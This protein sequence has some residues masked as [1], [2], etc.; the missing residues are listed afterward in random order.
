M[1]VSLNLFAASTKL[2]QNYVNTTFVDDAHAFGGQAQTHEAVF[3]LDPEAVMLQVRQE[4]RRV[5]LFA[6]EMLFPVTGPLP[7]T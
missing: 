4:R 3:R 1:T 7:V 6:W 2:G 5:L